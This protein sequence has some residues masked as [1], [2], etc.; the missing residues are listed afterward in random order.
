MK[1]DTVHIIPSLVQ[2]KIVMIY[3]MTKDI[4][5]REAVAHAVNSFKEASIRVK[6]K[7]IV[8]YLKV[9]IYNSINEID[10]GVDSKLRYDRMI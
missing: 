6:I 1:E 3:K 10:I 9:L 4:K 8:G 5:Y 2:K 7:K